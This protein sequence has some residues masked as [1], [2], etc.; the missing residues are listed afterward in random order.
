[1]TPSVSI[2]QAYS[3]PMTIV[4]LEGSERSVEII[5]QC[6]VRPSAIKETSTT[7]YWVLNDP[8][9]IRPYGVLMKEAGSGGGCTIA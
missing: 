2:A 6:R 4:D 5:L 8:S 1:V 3:R 9:D 7:G